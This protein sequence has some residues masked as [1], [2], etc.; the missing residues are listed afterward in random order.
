M[1]IPADLGALNPGEELKLQLKPTARTLI[2]AVIIAILIG[3]IPII[4]LFLTP[5]IL[6]LVIWAYFSQ[7]R[8]RRFFITTD[9]IILTRK[10]L[11]RDR[12]DLY[13]ENVSDFTVDQGIW[14][15]IFGFG[16]II[17]TTLA[18][19]SPEA[20]LRGRKKKASPRT[21]FRLGGIRNPYEANN[22]LQSLR[23]AKSRQQQGVVTREV[24]VTCRHCGARAPQGT[25]RCPSCGA[26]L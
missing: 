22:T 10:F 4:D 15:R 23:V 3:F 13:L 19:L 26:N 11:S 25:L 7:V 6:L 18:T 5:L 21:L 16:A 17:P 20:T 14:G 2:P 1:G 9:R 12:R 24:L 8:A